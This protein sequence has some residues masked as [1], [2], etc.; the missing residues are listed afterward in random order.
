MIDTAFE[1]L[2]IDK[3]F[4]ETFNFLRSHAIRYDQQA[5]EKSARQIHNGYQPMNTSKK[6]KIKTVLE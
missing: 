4:T 6:E 2:V 5:K 1:A 3:P